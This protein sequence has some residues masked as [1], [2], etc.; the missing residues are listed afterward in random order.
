[1]LTGWGQGMAAE[2]EVPQHVDL[3]LTKPP[4]LRQLRE[5][6]ASV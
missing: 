1:M 6:L 2:G 5:A 4:K 3:M